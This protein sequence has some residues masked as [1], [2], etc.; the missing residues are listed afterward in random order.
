ME[1]TDNLYRSE[2][3]GNNP[4]SSL[5]QKGSGEVRSNTEIK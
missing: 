4:T 3:I 1:T 2:S 5:S